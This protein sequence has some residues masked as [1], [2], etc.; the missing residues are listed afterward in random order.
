MERRRSWAAAGRLPPQLA[1]RFTLAE[2]AV[3]AVVS[4]EVAK[5]GA[6]T[7]T[8]GHIAAVAGVSE[9]TVRNAMREAQG[10]GLLRV[11]ERRLT[12]WRNAPNR[13]TVVSA[14]WL[15]WMRLRPRGGG[16]KSANPTP[17]GLHRTSTSRPAQPVKKAAGGQ[18]A[19]LTA[20]SQIPTRDGQGR[21]EARR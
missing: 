5:H 16:C 4:M 20:R 15:A 8:I 19:E 10:L 12:A 7:L 13:V 18:R 1:A 2:A 3:L 17:T 9:T 6:C 14:E 21:G 11:E